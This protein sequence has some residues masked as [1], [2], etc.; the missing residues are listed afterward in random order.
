MSEPT[1]NQEIELAELEIRGMLYQVI[2]LT[3]KDGRRCVYTGQPQ[4]TD[5]CS[6]VSVVA[7]EPMRL[8]PGMTWETLPSGE[9]GVIDENDA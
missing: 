7:S 2:T 8:P 1:D 4:I 5:P 9:I 3:T 6:I